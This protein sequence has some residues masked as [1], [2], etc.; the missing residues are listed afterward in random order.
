M[1]EVK[2]IIRETLSEHE[3]VIT[4]TGDDGNAVSKVYDPTSEY[5]TRTTTEEAVRE[6]QQN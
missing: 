4:V 2:D 5:E 1:A 6:I 3:A